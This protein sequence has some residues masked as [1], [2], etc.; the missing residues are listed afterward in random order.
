MGR[1]TMR[2]EAR[3]IR[4]RG[5]VQ[6]VGF[7]PHVWHL[8][9]A[10]GL[11]GHVANDGEGVTITAWGNPAQLAEFATR[12]TTDAPPL[13]RID[14]IEQAAHTGAAPADFT[15]LASHASA[16]R[17]AIVPD[18]ATCPA[19]RA[20]LFDPADRRH[21]Y[22][23]G[24]C[25]HCGPRLTIIRAIPYDRANTA[26]APFAMCATCAAEY[27]DLG[28]MKELTKIHQARARTAKSRTRIE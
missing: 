26:M 6:G 3:A 4:V 23:F 22:A 10:L 16:P 2:L 11:V 7:R 13:A 5:L 15:I 9:R 19:C 1:E 20:E 17:T 24:N 25:T 8:A 28:A 12:L 27:A 18:A 14:T 21:G